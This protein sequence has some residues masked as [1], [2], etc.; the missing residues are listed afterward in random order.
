MQRMVEISY[1]K[2]WGSGRSQ[3]TNA[4]GRAFV[5]GPSRDSRRSL[6]SRGALRSRLSRGADGADGAHQTNGANRSFVSGPARRSSF[7]LNRKK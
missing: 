6:F 5:S 7:S 2:A 3:G 1:R 4:S